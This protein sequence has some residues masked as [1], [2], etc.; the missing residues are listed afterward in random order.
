MFLPIESSA[1]PPESMAMQAERDSATRGG[2]V[3]RLP[4]LFLGVLMFGVIA[5][6]ATTT[7][8]PVLYNAAATAAELDGDLAAAERHLVRAVETGRRFGAQDSVATALDRLVGLYTLQ[9][10]D[11]EAEAM[12]EELLALRTDRFG[13]AHPAVA[14]VLEDLGIAAKQQGRLDDAEGWF[15]RSLGVR[16]A[17]FGGH[18]AQ[19]ASA[20]LQLGSLYRSQ[21]E[22]RR[23]DLYL[24]RAR[25]IL[26]EQ[27][28]AAHEPE[29]FA[30]VPGRPDRES[31]GRVL[32]AATLYELS[33]VRTLEHQ[34][35]EAHHLAERVRDV[36]RAGRLS[37]ALEVAALSHLGALEHAQGNPAQSAASF[38]DAR[39]VIRDN[40]L[41]GTSLE[42][43]L[44]RNVALSDARASDLQLARR[45]MRQHL[46]N[47][48][49]LAISVS[50]ND[51][52]SDRHRRPR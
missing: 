42:R 44:D 40:A 34:L 30:P 47:H 28:P 5:V 24:A 1:W 16:E 9:Q 38:A 50:W 17:A 29:L 27:V 19:T 4:D 20:F 43:S 52:L 13:E 2:S 45:D 25:S 32:L 37:P 12:L 35:V 7:L 22:L 14:E 23:A 8:R 36:A 21:G 48:G 26:E 15:R 18:H 51:A 31:T 33:A 10:R 11:A 39:R 49:A 6:I 46:T 41:E 3:L